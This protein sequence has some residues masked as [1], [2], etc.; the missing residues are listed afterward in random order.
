MTKVTSAP[1]TSGALVLM[2]MSKW[3][4]SEWNRHTHSRAHAHTH[5]HSDTLT[6]SH[7][8]TQRGTIEVCV[9]SSV[10]L[11]FESRSVAATAWPESPRARARVKSLHQQ[12]RAPVAEC[13]TDTPV[14]E[15]LLRFL[16]LKMKEQSRRIW[17]YIILRQYYFFIN[18]TF[19]FRGI[20]R[21]RFCLF[22]SF[23]FG[24]KHFS[25]MNCF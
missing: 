1:L 9:F 15:S 11:V 24:V 3:R 17:S 5:I 25:S 8:H 6:H 2:L 7:T 19:T 14:T 10:G 20:Q 22:L 21:T 4:T 13:A 12:P 16:L 23:W 18:Y